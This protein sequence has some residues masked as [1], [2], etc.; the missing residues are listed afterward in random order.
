M[1][2]RL[3]RRTAPGISPED[4]LARLPV[5]D[6]RATRGTLAEASLDR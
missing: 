6:L 5:D 4:S 3:C 1:V 2:T